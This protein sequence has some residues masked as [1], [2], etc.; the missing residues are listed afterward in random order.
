M[1]R[2]TNVQWWVLVMVALSIV[3]VWPP[4]GDKSL[5]IK[6]V[7]WAVDPRGELP[8]RPR[9][10]SMELGDDLDAIE[11]HSLRLQQYDTLYAKGGWSR[12]RLE[13]KVAKDP[14]NPATERQ[15]LTGIGVLAPWQLGAFYQNSPE[16][17]VRG[18]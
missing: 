12:K 7:N 2:A 3:F 6:V 13:L 14:F 17:S 18:P 4:I 15:L 8:T 11:E 10:L 16:S 1:W 5:A 9:P